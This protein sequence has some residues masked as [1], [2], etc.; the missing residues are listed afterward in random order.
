MLLDNIKV[1]KIL[2]LGV[3]ESSASGCKRTR[4]KRYRNHQDNWSRIPEYYSTSRKWDKIIQENLQ[5]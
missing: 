4:S 5:V 1:F 2:T 3:C